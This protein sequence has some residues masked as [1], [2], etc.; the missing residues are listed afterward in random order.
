M[1][2]ISFKIAVIFKTT[3]ADIKKKSADNILKMITILK[4]IRILQLCSK[5][6]WT[7]APMGGA[8]FSG[9]IF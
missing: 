6:E 2:L 1:I 7:L 5:S 9:D 8:E 4:E 3:S